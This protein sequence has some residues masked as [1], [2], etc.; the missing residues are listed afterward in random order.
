MDF[1]FEYVDEPNSE[2]QKPIDRGLQDKFKDPKLGAAFLAFLMKRYMTSGHNIQVP[3]EVVLS[4]TEFV[5]SNNT[6]VEILEDL[7]EAGEN[8]SVTLKEL[9]DAIPARKKER[10]GIKRYSLKKSLANSGKCVSLVHGYPILRGYRLR[11][12]LGSSIEN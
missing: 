2:M 3:E 9:W 11:E 10:E 4:S 5:N 7:C 12:E 8:Y 6:I 1:P